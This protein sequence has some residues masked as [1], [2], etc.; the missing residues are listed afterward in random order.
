MFVTMTYVMR[1]GIVLGVT[2]PMAMG[3]IRTVLS[4]STGGSLR[5]GMIDCKEVQMAETLKKLSDEEVEVTVTTSE[6]NVYTKTRLLELKARY[7]GLL[8]AIQEKLDILK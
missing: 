2:C 1:E 5:K 3:I 4:M 8:A 7:D 6:V